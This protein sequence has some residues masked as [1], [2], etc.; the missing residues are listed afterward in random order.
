MEG[1]ALVS[2]CIIVHSVFIKSFVLKCVDK[3]IHDSS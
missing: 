2:K 1:Y 3:G